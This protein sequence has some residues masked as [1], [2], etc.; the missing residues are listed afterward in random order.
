MDV[1]KDYARQPSTW[2]G[3]IKIGVALGLISTGF[4]SAVSALVVAALGVVDVVRKEQ[5]KQN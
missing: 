1:L 2:L 5:T 4:G 3:F